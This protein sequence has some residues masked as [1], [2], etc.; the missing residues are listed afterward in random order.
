MMERL[1]LK[2]LTTV[3]P[4]VRTAAYRSGQ[5]NYKTVTEVNK[6]S[7]FYKFQEFMHAKY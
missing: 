1:A 2:V 7:H 6:C 5:S 4:S 3:I